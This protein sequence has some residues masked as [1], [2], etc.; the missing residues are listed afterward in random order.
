M[1]QEMRNFWLGVISG[2]I[3]MFLVAI[4]TVNLLDL[5]PLVSP[6]IGGLV[7]GYITRKDILT[8]G[9][10]GILTGVLGAV[11]ISLDF[12]IHT[13]FLQRVT[14]AFQFFGV[15]I[16]VLGVI[17]YFAILGSIGGAI[18]GFLRCGYLFCRTPSSG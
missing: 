2:L 7:A 12:L 14:V 5:I 18:G 17:I 13:G 10:A 15:D 3:V 16:F 1:E 8:G 9:K 4:V 11:M 6:F